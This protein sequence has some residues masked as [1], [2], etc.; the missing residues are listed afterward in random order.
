MTCATLRKRANERL[1]W[2]I[3]FSRFLEAGD[4]LS[5]V[6]VPLI[7]GLNVDTAIE[8]DHVRVWIDGGEAGKAYKLP[9]KATT[10]GGRTVIDCMKLRVK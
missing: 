3:D 9:L 7:D 4:S 6:S 1:D 8:G 2:L 5:S 10:A